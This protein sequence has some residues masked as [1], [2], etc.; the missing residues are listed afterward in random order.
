MES[1]SV[2]CHTTQVNTARLNPSQ[3]PVLDL[4]T[5]EGWKAEL[6]YVTGYNC[7]MVYPPADGHPSKYQPS[8]AWP[9]VELATYLL[10]PSPTP[11]PVHPKP[12]VV[13]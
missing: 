1:H 6:T 2:S 12:P 7:E 9:G 4:P 11:Y 5:P 8:S 3:R 13:G 10:I